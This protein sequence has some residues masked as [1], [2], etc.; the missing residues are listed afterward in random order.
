MY[1]VH[2]VKVAVDEKRAGELTEGTSRL[3]FPCELFRPITPYK[4]KNAWQEHHE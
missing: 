4:K 1:I 2:T 3:R